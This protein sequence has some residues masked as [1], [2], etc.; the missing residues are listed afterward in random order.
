MYLFVCLFVFFFFFW[1]I[2]AQQMFEFIYPKQAQMFEMMQ[3][4]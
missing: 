3:N 4:Q 2:L 1:V